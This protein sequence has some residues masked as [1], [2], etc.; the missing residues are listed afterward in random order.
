MVAKKP[1]PRSTGLKSPRKGSESKRELTVVFNNYGDFPI[2]EAE[3][4]SLELH[5]GDIIASLMALNNMKRV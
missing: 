1:P 2:G 5:M 4:S 3:L